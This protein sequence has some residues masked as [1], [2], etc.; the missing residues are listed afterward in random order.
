M[1]GFLALEKV[2][3]VLGGNFKNAEIC[4]NV[5]QTLSTEDLTIPVLFSDWPVVRK[6]ARNLTSS[7]HSGLTIVQLEAT[8]VWTSDGRGIAYLLESNCSEKY[9]RPRKSASLGGIK[10]STGPESDRS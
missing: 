6:S 8:Q 7:I 1:K 2:V 5:E 4:L 9:T 3:N 10:R